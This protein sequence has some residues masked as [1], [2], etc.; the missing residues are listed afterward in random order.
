M[1]RFWCLRRVHTEDGELVYKMEPYLDI[2]PEISML[3]G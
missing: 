3:Y 1:F 2:Y